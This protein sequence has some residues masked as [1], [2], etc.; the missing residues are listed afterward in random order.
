MRLIIDTNQV[1]AI[2]RT[3]PTNSIGPTLVIPPLV[4]SELMRSPHYGP[5]RANALTAYDILFG[6]DIST[7]LDEFAH[8]SEKQIRGVESVFR[9]TS[10]VHEFLM[11]GFT[12]PTA[13]HFK[14][15]DELKQEADEFA[16]EVIERAKKDAQKYNNMRSRGDQLDFVK[17]NTIEDAEALLLADENATWAA[18][19]LALVTDN[20]TKNTKAKSKASLHEAI[21]DNSSVRL[22]T[23]VAITMSFGYRACWTDETLNTTPAGNDLTD[24]SITAYARPGN[25]ILTAEKK[26]KRAIRHSDPESKFE[27]MTWAE[28]VAMREK[29]INERR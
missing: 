3:Q 23:R 17:W 6:I 26:L 27:V 4:W 22:W 12:N 18:A 10:D 15:A 16:K 24:V 29:Q 11:N 21:M 25:A 13:A 20:D 8:L 1:D 5:K 7:L 14:R 28:Y 19:T 9:P 2:L